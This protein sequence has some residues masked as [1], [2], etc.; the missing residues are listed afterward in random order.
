L[1]LG[2]LGGIF[3]LLS[4]PVLRA[5]WY[6]NCLLKLMSYCCLCTHT[7]RWRVSQREESQNRNKSLSGG[8]K[9]VDLLYGEVEMLKVSKGG[10][11]G[12]DFSFFLL[13]KLLI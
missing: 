5:K 1:S 11:S 3:Y 4:K 13:L 6:F 12:G 9:Y 7:H 2:I 8:L 10:V